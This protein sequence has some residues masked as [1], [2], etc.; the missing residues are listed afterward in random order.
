MTSLKWYPH[1]GGNCVIVNHSGDL[2]KYIN[3]ILWR[4]EVK[5]AENWI[6]NLF[7]LSK[8]PD[9]SYTSCLESLDNQDIQAE[10]SIPSGTFCVWHWFCLSKGDDLFL[11]TIGHFLHSDHRHRTTLHLSFFRLKKGSE[12]CLSLIQKHTKQKVLYSISLEYG[13]KHPGFS[14]Q[15][16]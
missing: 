2:I 13:E 9:H 8:L 10:E 5:S 12:C 15:P 3:H 14:R 4:Q 6:R 11:H 16:G 7:F 1:H